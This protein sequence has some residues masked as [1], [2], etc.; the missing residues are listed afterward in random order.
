MSEKTDSTTP[1]KWLLAIAFLVQFGCGTQSSGDEAGADTV[2]PNGEKAAAKTEAGRTDLAKGAI[3]AYADYLKMG[4]D[5]SAS[6]Q[7]VLLSNIGGA[8]KKGGPEHAVQ[9]CNVNAMSIVD[10]LSTE[11]GMKIGRISSRNRNPGNRIKTQEDVRAWTYFLNNAGVGTTPDTVLYNRAQKAVYYKP[12]RI[13][14]ETCLKCHGLRSSDIAVAT[15]DKIDELYPT[16]NAVNY[17]MG[18]L[19]GLWKVEFE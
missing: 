19:R 10:S 17:R 1:V 18:D 4:K 14:T 9:F 8:I 12:I 3:Y 5:A 6:T 13:G 7:A 2:S 11:A 15:L 16:D